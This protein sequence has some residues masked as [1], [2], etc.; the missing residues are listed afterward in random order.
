MPQV[1]LAP[2]RRDD[3]P[4]TSHRPS[5]EGDVADPEALALAEEILDD[6]RGRSVQKERRFDDGRRRRFEARR[7]PIDD[8]PRPV[9]DRR[10]EDDDVELEL[11]EL[12]RAAEYRDALL[13]GAGH[14]RPEGRHAEAI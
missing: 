2:K 1:S 5:R 6:R 4:K 8:G 7:Q 13:D 10:V 9:G 11:R 12:R 14:D 3:G